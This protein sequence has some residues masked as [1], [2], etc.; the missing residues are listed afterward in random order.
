M[1]VRAA[2]LLA[3]VPLAGCGDYRGPRATMDRTTGVM[4]PYTLRYAQTITP[5][6]RLQLELA[7]WAHH[8]ALD[9]VIVSPAWQNALGNPTR[10]GALWPARDV[11]VY[12]L[13]Y[14]N[15]PTHLAVQGW[16]DQDDRN[17]LHLVAGG[18]DELPAATAMLVRSVYLPYDTYQQ[19]PA[20]PFV[21]GLQDQ[22]NRALRQQRGFP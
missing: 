3:L 9:V 8:S 17:A 18:A 7:L 12:D 13:A 19:G 22:T 11:Y 16:V 15:S 14:L 21:L 6:R 10:I 4:G 20:W 5:T 1:T 2:F